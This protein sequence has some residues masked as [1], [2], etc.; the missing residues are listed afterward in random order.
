MTSLVNCD[1][2]VPRLS[3]RGFAE[4]LQELSDFDW[5]AAAEARAAAHSGDGSGLQLQQHLEGLL[6][7][8]MG[9]LANGGGGGGGKGGG[10]GDGGG[11]GG[12]DAVAAADEALHAAAAAAG[13]AGLQR[14]GS[15]GFERSYNAHVPG[16]VL[17]VYRPPG[18]AKD[19]DGEGDAAAE[20]ASG[21][22]DGM[23]LVP[24]THRAVRRLRVSP[25][26]VADHFIDGPE[27]MAAL[28][29]AESE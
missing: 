28:G 3:I 9:G 7:S 18:A 13:E 24:T 5:R 12:D 8:V 16:R 29:E 15:A 6:H 21:R 11:D 14:L 17:L 10:D 27:I 2:C 1:D 23:A 19:E 4:L 26:M 20:A 25:L 22:R